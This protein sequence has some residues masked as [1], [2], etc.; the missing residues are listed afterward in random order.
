MASALPAQTQQ[1]PQLG[2]GA[3]VIYP[4]MYGEL[5]L[6]DSARTHI[7]RAFPL[8]DVPPQ[9]LSATADAVYCERQGDGAL[10]DGM[11]CRVDRHTYAWT[12]RVFPF[13]HATDEGE[14]PRQPPTTVQWIVNKPVGN[15]FSTIKATGSSLIVT[16]SDGQANADPL[17]LELRAF[18]R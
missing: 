8:Y 7:V 12:V 15:L 2:S 14:P 11:L 18:R 13:D 16:G 3:G 5:L 9:R 17:T 6:L 4:A 10:T 1:A